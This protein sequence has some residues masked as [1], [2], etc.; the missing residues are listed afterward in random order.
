M[1][2]GYYSFFYLI[3][4]NYFFQILPG[5]SNTYAVA[6]NTL[7]PAIFASKIRLV[8]YSDHPRTVCMRI[9]L[10]GCVFQGKLLE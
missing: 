3:T 10:V 9:E 2:L 1:G 6:N 5:N 4:D 7:N 8:P